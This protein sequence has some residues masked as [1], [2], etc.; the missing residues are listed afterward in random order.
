MAERQ[1]HGFIYEE[2]FINENKLIKEKSYTAKFDARNSE[3]TPYQIKTIRLG[4]S[5]DLGDY[6]RNANI[7]ED[8]FLIISFWKE[9]RQD[10]VEVHKLFID[11]NEWK[12]L[13]SFEKES[14]MKDWIKNRVSNSYS[15]D[16]Q[17][18]EETKYFKEKFGK[19]KVALR[20]KR[21]HKT[22]RRIQCAINKTD[23]YSYFIPRFEVK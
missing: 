15:Y 1:E 14:E 22:Q 5:I 9:K 13:F 12:K 20:F 19:R 8:F 7:E 16:E 10:I 23:F 4:S 17:W 18:K 3:G 11:C 2:H 21:D 6:F